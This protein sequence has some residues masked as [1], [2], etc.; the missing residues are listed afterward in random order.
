MNERGYL[1]GSEMA[2]TFNMLRSNDLVWSFVINNYLLGKEPF[3]FDLLY[4]N[5]DSTR[6]PAKMHSFYL[7]NMYLRNAL[8]EP[9]GMTLGGVP[10]D[11]AQGEDAGVLHLHRRGPH[12]AVEVD[13]P[14]RALPRRARCG[15]CSAARATS[16]AS[17]TRR[18]RR[19][20]TTGR[21]DELPASPDDWQ[22]ARN[23]P[24]GLVVE[25]LAGVDGRAQRRRAG[26][27]APAG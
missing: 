1:E 3:P 27:G 20:I 23:P 15:S 4:W 12:R 24:R 16:P 7:R 10:I 5:S 8:K 26:A 19:S 18:R 11:L 17:S 13:L 6:M 2:G 14:R 25:R 21:N 22:S 9:G